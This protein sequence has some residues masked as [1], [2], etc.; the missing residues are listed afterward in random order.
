MGSPYASGGHQE[1]PACPRPS[2][3]IKIQGI[4]GTQSPVWLSLG[5]RGDVPECLVLGLL[6]LI[7][8]HTAASHFQCR[9]LYSGCLQPPLHTVVLTLGAWCLGFPAFREGYR[10]SFPPVLASTDFKSVTTA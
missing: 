8:L 4:H 7:A 9:D 1:V 6:G 3:K 5:K 2:Q 10:E